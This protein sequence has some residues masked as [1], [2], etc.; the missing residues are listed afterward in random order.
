[1]CSQDTAEATGGIGVSSGVREKGEERDRE[2]RYTGREK[3][4]ERDESKSAWKAN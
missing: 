4:T 3:E 2:N 1:M